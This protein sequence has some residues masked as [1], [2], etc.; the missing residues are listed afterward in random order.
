MQDMVAL[1]DK[2]LTDAKGVDGQE[3]NVQQWDVIGY[4]QSRLGATAYPVSRGF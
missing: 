3:T 1:Y 4:D 2:T